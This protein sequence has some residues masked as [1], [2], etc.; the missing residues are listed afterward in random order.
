MAHVYASCDLGVALER[1][2]AAGHSLVIHPHAE[3]PDRATLARELAAAEGLVCTLRDP[4][5]AELL[6]GAPRLR[7]V[8][9][10]AVGLDNVDLEACRARGIAVVHTPDVLTAA[11]A[12]F[13]LFMMGALARRLP[14]SELLVREQRWRG[15]H[16]S[17]P[18]LGREIAGLSVG[19]LG[20]GRI[21][22]AFAGRCIGLDVDLLLCDP[23]HED[24]A[25]LE[26][27]DAQLRIRHA[28]GL[29][30]RCRVRWVD[31]DTLHA[32]ADVVSLHVPLRPATRGLLDPRRM[33]P[34]ALLVNAARGG[35]VDE[36]A[37]VEALRSGHLGGAALDVYAVEPLPADSPL[38]APDLAD[39]L[40][41]YHH[42]GSGTTRTRLD[43]DPELGM[44]GRCVEGLLAALAGDR[45]LPYVL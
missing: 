45:S 19:V 43:P 12:E 4:I 44:A 17:L 14:A 33:K 15:W 28:A 23:R 29:G 34:G 18:F 16:P 37:L 3:A 35:V 20:L 1:V 8:A 25:L 36:E 7:A 26:A 40:R 38:R 22:R 24:P 27:L 5:D 13:A 6:A 21:G 32:E 41:L 9:Q 39:R 42:F 31:L 2:P 11:T 10:C 30:P